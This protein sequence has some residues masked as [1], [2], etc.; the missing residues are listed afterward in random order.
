MPKTNLI[1]GK[2]IP[3]FGTILNER[4]E[5]MSFEVYKAIQKEQTKQL[6]RRLRMGFYEKT[7]YNDP[8]SNKK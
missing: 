2:Q 1:P 8:K 6:K 3:K 4:P 7:N 5:G